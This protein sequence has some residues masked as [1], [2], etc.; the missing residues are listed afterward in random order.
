MWDTPNISDIQIFNPGLLFLGLLSFSALPPLTFSSLFL[1][2][3]QLFLIVQLVVTTK[4]LQN[5]TSIVAKVDPPTSGRT[6]WCSTRRSTRTPRPD[7]K[8][9]ATVTTMETMPT[10]MMMVVTQH[11][12]TMTK[13][14]HGGEMSV[15]MKLG[16]C[17]KLVKKKPPYT[18][19]NLI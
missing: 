7:T 17:Q 14:H 12:P 4:L 16:M 3:S 15:M 13:S 1:F 18:M 9:G 8:Q 10:V 2:L 11:I 6:S 5:Q 19:M